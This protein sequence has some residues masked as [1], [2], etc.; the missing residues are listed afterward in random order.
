MKSIAVNIINALFILLF[1][2]TALSKIS[3]YTKF[4]FV[5][6]MAPLVRNYTTWIA[7]IIPATELIIAAL[8][9]IPATA[10]KGLIAGISLLIVFTVYLV[11]M[12]LTDPN[13][14]CSCGGVI[15]Q[16]SWKQ[17]IVFNMFFIAAGTVGI[18]M[19]RESL[20]KPKNL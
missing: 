4:R 12:I 2:Y 8:I 7:A 14:P 15:Q 9:F 1:T 17:H 10:K 3:G 19:H 18:Y 13:L 16:L 5:L 20:K 11:Y 6:G